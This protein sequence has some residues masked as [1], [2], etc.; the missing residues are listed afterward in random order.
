M[1]TKNMVQQG[2]VDLRLRHELLDARQT[3]V[4]S[5]IRRDCDDVF[6]LKNLRRHALVLNLL[7]M[8]DRFFGQSGRGQKL[9]W[10]IFNDE[11]LALDTPALRLQMRIDGWDSGTQRFIAGDENDIGMVGCDRLGVINRRTRAAE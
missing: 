9:N 2:L 7:R 8:A 3:F 5:D 10:E 11:M 6:R 4:S 1:P